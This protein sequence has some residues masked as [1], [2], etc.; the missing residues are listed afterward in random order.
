MFRKAMLG[1]TATLN[2]DFTTGVLDSRLTFTRST[3]ATYINS[4]GYITSAAINAPRFD[5]SPTTIGEPR[6]LLIEGQ[7]TN[8]VNYS[9]GMSQSPW[10]YATNVLLTVNL[11]GTA[12]DGTNNTASRISMTGALGASSSF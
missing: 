5:Y 7:A 12:P 8:L 6:G 4:S 2:L 11:G 10:F 9:T 1:D 3:T